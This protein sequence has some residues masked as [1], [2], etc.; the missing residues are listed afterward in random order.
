MH[1]IYTGLDFLTT[2]P[3]MWHPV[4][5]AVLTLVQWTLVSRNLLFSKCVSIFC[6]IISL[7]ADYSAIWVR[8]LSL[9]T[10]KHPDLSPIASLTMQSLLQFDSPLKDSEIFGVYRK[11]ANKKILVDVKKILNDKIKVHSSYYF[12]VLDIYSHIY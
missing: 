4:Q 3:S 11:V 7:L 2:S 1:A 9:Y 6:L 5:T 12:M 8:T 10:Y